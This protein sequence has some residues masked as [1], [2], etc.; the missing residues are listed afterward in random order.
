MAITSQ[1]HREHRGGPSKR[2]SPRS[3]SPLLVIRGDSPL[4]R[5]RLR[6]PSKRVETRWRGP[7]AR[8][9]ALR[10]S[11]A[12]GSTLDCRYLDPRTPSPRRLSRTPREAMAIDWHVAC[13]RPWTRSGRTP[14]SD[15]G[16]NFLS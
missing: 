10:H 15:E 2:L 3:Q 16:Y 4:H 8:W 9:R 7:A 1:L 11:M 6:G 12:K 5:D 13:T 14:D